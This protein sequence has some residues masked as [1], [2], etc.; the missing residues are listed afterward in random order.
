MREVMD[1]RRYQL[2]RAV[3][4]REVQRRL[5]AIEDK[6]RPINVLGAIKL[7]LA[8]QLARRDGD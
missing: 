6:E 5:R 2:Y 3:T 4:L 7:W 1:D 8:G